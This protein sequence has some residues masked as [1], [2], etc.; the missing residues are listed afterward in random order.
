MNLPPQIVDALAHTENQIA[1]ALRVADVP[2]DGTDEST[3]HRAVIE[4][5]IL[6]LYGADIMIDSAPST[7]LVFT[8]YTPTV[9]RKAVVDMSFDVDATTSVTH[10]RPM[11]E[12]PGV[13]VFRPNTPSGAWDIMR[14]CVHDSGSGMGCSLS[15][16]SENAYTDFV[17][18]LR[19]YQFEQ[20]T[21]LQH[22]PDAIN[23]GSDLTPEQAATRNTTWLQEAFTTL[24]GWDLWKPLSELENHGNPAP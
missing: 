6:Q 22:I 23:A 3:L 4:H 13:L 20:H 21:V 14:F 2:N 1:D 19:N 11:S 18:P 12:T 24:Q 7:A 8:P 17:V 15:K 16:L 10:N 5:A 9:S